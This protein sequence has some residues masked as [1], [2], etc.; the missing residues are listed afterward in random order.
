M[1]FN[2]GR[3]LCTFHG[4]W[5]YRATLSILR[6]QVLG[7]K[8]AHSLEFPKVLKKNKGYQKRKKALIVDS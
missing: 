4:G 7:W 3:G 8:K 5:Y 1:A 6:S 2:D